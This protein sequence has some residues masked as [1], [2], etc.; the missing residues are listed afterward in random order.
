MKKEIIATWNREA[1]NYSQ[2]VQ[3]ELAN[4]HD[5]AWYRLV[6]AYLP[7]DKKLKILDI[8]CGPGMF[9]IMFSLRGHDVTGIDIS[10]NMIAQA[11]QNA[12]AYK[13]FPT[14]IVSD[15][16]TLVRDGNLYDVIVSRDMV[17]SL[18][19][20]ENT[21]RLLK[22]L[23]NDEGMFMIFDAN[24][25]YRYHNTDA[26]NN[27]VQ[28]LKEYEVTYNVKLSHD[29]EASDQYKAETPLAKFKRPQWDINTLISIGYET[30][31]CQRDISL[32]V[33][34]PDKQLLYRSTPEFL[35][36]GKK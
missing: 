10:E 8:G 22:E 25:N 23:L 17:W 16:E 24:W 9:S 33:R 4:N 1:S 21:F 36:V 34:A 35:V 18:M 11:Q 29:H 12:H 32:V 6:E 27:Y 14:F 7:N 26:H 3:D 30:V 5:D 20:P 31:I 19:E 2:L 28:D 13:V 15:I